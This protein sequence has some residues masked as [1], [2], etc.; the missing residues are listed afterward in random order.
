MKRGDIVLVNLDA[1]VS[2]ATKAARPCPSNSEHRHGQVERLLLVGSTGHCRPRAD[3]RTRYKPN[4]GNAAAQVVVRC[5]P[6]FSGGFGVA[7][8]RAALRPPAPS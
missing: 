4:H 1:S 2:K 3:V 7:V 5:F 8:A 6:G